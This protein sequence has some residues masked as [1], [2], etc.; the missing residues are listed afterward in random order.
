[1]GLKTDIDDAIDAFK[2]AK[3]K[4]N[5]AQAS[6]DLSQRRLESDRHRLAEL[7][8]KLTDAHRSL[9]NANGEPE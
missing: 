5:D 4:C 1:M 2:E 8:Q 6:F 7:S 3:R 9:L